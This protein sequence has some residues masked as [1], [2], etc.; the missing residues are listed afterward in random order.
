MKIFIY[1]HFIYE[2]DTIKTIKEKL[3]VALPHD[4]AL[5]T[6]LIPKYTYTWATKWD[7]QD[8]KSV[9]LG[10]DWKIKDDDWTA[11]QP[12]PPK[13]IDD[14]IDVESN[15]WLSDILDEFNAPIRRVRYI[16]QH[17]ILYRSYEANFNEIYFRD[18]LHDLFHVTDKM[19]ESLPVL[20]ISLFKIYYP[21]IH[22]Q[23]IDN[24]IYPFSNE[25]KIELFNPGSFIIASLFQSEVPKYWIFFGSTS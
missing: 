12:A 3:C 2:D 17:D 25:T 6:V 20:N 11:F 5:E 23:D 10:F 14:L 4:K 15:T 16:D 8:R 18:I 24:C 19:K 1:S 13:H 9:A 21:G 7:K 22:L